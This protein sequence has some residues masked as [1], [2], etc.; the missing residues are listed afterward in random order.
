MNLTIAAALLAVFLM[1]VIAHALWCLG[2]GDEIDELE[3]FTEVLPEPSLA[4]CIHECTSDCKWH[5]CNC[6]CGEYHCRP[7]EPCRDPQTECP[8]H[9]N[10]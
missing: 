2:T 1:G 7:E 5:G 9:L 6:A 4:V 3:D 8:N 10:V